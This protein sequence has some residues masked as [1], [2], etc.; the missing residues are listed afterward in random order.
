MELEDKLKDI[1]SAVSNGTLRTLECAV[2]LYNQTYDRYPRTT[3]FLSTAAGTIGGD[4][5]AK[6]IVGGEDINLRDVA[7]TTFAAV[8]QSYLYPKLIDCTERIADVGLVKKAYQKL[9]ISKEWAKTFII[10]GLFFIPNMLYWGLLSVKNQAQI[11]TKTALQAAKS[12]GIGSI[13][14]LGVDYLVTNKLKKR[15]CLPVWSAAEVVY[16]S[17]LAGVAY[18]T[19]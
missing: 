5:I 8:Y 11:T 6:K 18:L 9:G 1:G 15:Y 13:P 4:Y 10:G 14:Y 12:I 16:N 7:F 2:D 3:K 19:K 17:F